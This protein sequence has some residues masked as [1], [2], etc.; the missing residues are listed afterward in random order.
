M[1]ITGALGVTLVDWT[2]GLVLS[3]AGTGP[4]GDPAA[5]AADAA[6][7][8]R[9]VMLRQAFA[10]P[11]AGG[12]SAEDVIVTSASVYHLLRFVDTSFDGNLLIHLRLDRNTANLAMARIRLTAII[13]RMVST[14]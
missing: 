13:D 9:V 6:E 7:L 2:G 11:G 12:S 10:D 5:D 4:D 3:A 8:A 1:S 14:S